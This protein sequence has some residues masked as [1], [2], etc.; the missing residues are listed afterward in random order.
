ME[1]NEVVWTSSDKSLQIVL[2]FVQKRQ[3]KYYYVGKTYPIHTQCLLWVNGL[4]LTFETVIKHDRDEHDPKFA[5][6]LCAEKALKA[7]H[8]K[9]TRSQVRIELNKYIEAL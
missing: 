9:W 5:H 4:L 6:K 2:Q 7:I 1:K 8:N 3:L